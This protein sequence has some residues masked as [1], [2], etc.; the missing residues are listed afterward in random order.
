MFADLSSVL[1]SD[2]TELGEPGAST[3]ISGQLRNTNEEPLAGVPVEIA[4]RTVVT[5]AQGFFR[6]ELPWSA[7][8]TDSFSIPVPAGDPYFDPYNTGTATIPMRR[9]RFDATTG[10]ELGDPLQH[11]NLIT[12]FIDA[13][14]VY[15]SDDVRAAELRTG[16]D[17]KLKTSDGDLMPVND[18]ATF[19]NG[20]HA[21]DNEG[22]YDP[23]TLF[24]GGD[25]RANEN[26]ALTSLH[27]LLVREHNRLADQ[28]KAEN[29]T[30]T[31]EQIYQ[32]ARRLVN[33]IVQHITYDEYLPI[34]VGGDA[35][36][37]YSG[38]DETVDPAE[39]ALF[40]AAAYRVGHTQL[41]T[42]IL[43]L[44]ENMVSLPGGSL[45]LKN[46]FFNPQAIYDDGIE[47]YLRG[48]SVS[49]SE[50]IDAF[51]IDDV[52]NFLFGP[53]GSGG[54]D[55]AAINIQRGR[56]LGLPSYNQARLDFGLSAVS[57]FSEISSDPAVAAALEAAY[58][59]VDLVDIWVG[60]IA[61]D[62]VPGAQV[63][64][65][66]QQIIAD[67]FARTRDGDRYFYENGQF[68]ADEMMLIQG[69]TL[70]SL[71]ERNTPITGLPENVFLAGS[72]GAAPAA[73]YRLA[74]EVS[75]DYRAI[76]GH[77]NN[78][79][80]PTAGAANDNLATDFTV[81]Y[82]D[83][84]FSPAGADRPSTREI[85]NRVIAQ[86]ASIPS[87]AGTT[88]F[89][90]FW[91]QLLDH[92]LGLSP[93]GVS[94]DL[95]INGDAYVDSLTNV[96]YEFDSGKVNLLLGH[97]AFAGNENVILEPI[98]LTTADTGSQNVFAHFPGRIQYPGQAKSF[99][100]SIT[101]EDFDL[102]AGSI[103]LGWKLSPVAGSSLDPGAIRILN[104]F[105]LPVP[106][107]ISLHDLPSGDTESVVLVDL[108]PGEYQ[109][110]VSGQNLSTGQFILEAF[111]PG[112]SYGSRSVGVLQ[113]VSIMERIAGA[114]LLPDFN[115]YRPESDINVDGK[116]TEDDM[117]LALDN[118]F[119]ATRLNPIYL[120]LQLDPASDTGIPGD[121]VTSNSIVHL[122]G[123]A[124]PGSII[125]LDV[126]GDGIIDGQVVAGEYENGANYRYDALLT[127]GTHEVI[128]KAK[129]S[130][131]Q[132]ITRS[133]TLTRDTIAPHI[134]ATAP[135]S[136][137]LVVSGNAND[138]TI[139]IQLN[140]FAPLANIL[141][142]MSITGN[143]TGSVSPLG[144]RWNSSTR[145][146]SFEING[147]L[148]DTNYTISFAN[149][150]TD[151]AGNALTP[152]SFSFQRTV[153][154]GSLTAILSAGISYLQMG[155][156]SIY[157]SSQNAG[158]I[159]SLIALLEGESID[160]TEVDQAFAEDYA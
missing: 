153:V 15:G 149:T 32:Q 137:G 155:N 13:S 69:T 83:G 145:T 49:V 92:D 136:N 47:P 61:E 66:F 31:D 97:E 115:F 34:L 89:F 22:P 1:G 60:G 87:A 64:V 104:S 88:G 67:Q 58:G 99:S 124:T 12:S 56:D 150:V 3:W 18:L 65:L 91:G 29:P 118:I 90:V 57:S 38:Y 8:P 74:D 157:F 109:V 143:V 135:T 50:E 144:A 101:P 139:Q 52:R 25:V 26:V 140:E 126:N 84:Y 156:G 102:T 133:L 100:I 111:L 23:S 7:L 2:A 68:T 121:G 77:G 106:T 129:D 141:T 17:G 53:P 27:T 82:G 142:A 37:A 54:L 11:A 33:G 93:G 76:D 55:L 63:G 112:D 94:N 134:T 122:S 9:A 107:R 103:L 42:E 110:W 146:L 148:P 48:L 45:D 120:T 131:G 119:T 21:N 36:P 41:Y 117:Q 105:G 16:V 62:H 35:L 10:D 70:A 130:F 138:F 43:R 160:Q 158:A 114:D 78:L 95:N 51:V 108:H 24:V 96:T 127:E 80:D 125:T 59:D 147:A 113:V 39:S 152:F 71:I 154:P 86:S 6:I 72:A 30:F 151:L 5:D 44:D 20:M 159:L 116:M 46:A 128:V 75:T 40:A 73:P 4:G 98:Y 14:M 19:P 79:I 28:I 85:S 132:T 123:V 81:S